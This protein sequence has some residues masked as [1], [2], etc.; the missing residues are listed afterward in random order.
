MPRVVVVGGGF[1]GLAAV[2][3]LA[4]A[5]AEVVLVDRANH[6]LFQPLLYQVATASLSPADIA[7]PIR[8]ILRRQRN[9]EVVMAE[10]VDFDLGQ[11]TLELLPDREAAAAG[12]GRRQLG[13]DHLVVASGAV[14]SYFGHEATWG[15]I[16]TGLK[17]IDDAR[18]IRDRFLRAFEIAERIE[19][20]EA[21]RRAVTFV[22]VGG[23]PTG[24]EL[25]G[26]MAEIARRAL[27]G[28][29]RH[30][31]PATARIVLVDGAPRLLAAFSDDLGARAKRDLEALGVEVRLGA[32]VESVDNSGLV[33]GGTRLE[34]PNVFW[35]AGVTGSPLGRRLVAAAARNGVA[36]EIARGGRIVVDATLAVPGLDSVFVVGDLARVVDVDGRDVPG[37]APAALQMGGYVGR[38]LARKVTGKA[39]LPPFRYRD[40]G[41]LATIGRSRAVGALAGVRFGGLPAWW[42]WL[43]VHLM[44]LVGFRNRAIVLF[45]WAW[46]YLTFQRGARLI[47]GEAAK[48]DVPKG[49]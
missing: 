40:K 25:A 49:G 16:A 48:R 24:V 13:F 29:F 3:A 5:P 6:H 45:S 21:R 19:D 10:V 22:V 32:A 8:W 11:R 14:T 46:S 7:A 27:P 30:L 9:V 38:L 47:S 17:T 37:V 28:E 23:G 39:A 20:D 2:R 12:V 33:V 43:F 15:T 31:D 36:I 35:A 41:M 44:A 42:V 1:A 26:A 4:R 34:S 18:A